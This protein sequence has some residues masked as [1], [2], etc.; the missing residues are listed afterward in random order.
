M[1]KGQLL[2]RFDM[3]FISGKGYCLETPV[4]ITNSDKF[5]DVVETSS[6]VVVSGENLLNLLK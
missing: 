2:I 3:D 6:T 4:L 5:L 1:K